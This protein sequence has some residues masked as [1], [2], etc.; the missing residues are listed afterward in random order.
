[1]HARH[2]NT[3]HHYI[4]LFG[5]LLLNPGRI[6]TLESEN[7]LILSLSDQVGSNTWA[8]R[9]VQFI[10]ERAINIFLESRGI[11]LIISLND[12]RSGRGAMTAPRPVHDIQS[13]TNQGQVQHSTFTHPSG[14]ISIV[15]SYS[16]PSQ[17][18][19]PPIGELSTC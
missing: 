12:F 14:H 7:S 1:M 4:R 2:A 19:Q 18:A 15:N 6:R 17:A 16:P 3:I 10:A 13:V 5:H 9:C 8:E 11:A